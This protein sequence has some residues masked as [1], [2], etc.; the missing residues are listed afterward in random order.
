LILSISP[1]RSFA[2]IDGALITSAIMTNII[3]ATN[4]QD[5]GS[6]KNDDIKYFLALV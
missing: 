3:K 5:D 4:T 1:S 6:E 2:I